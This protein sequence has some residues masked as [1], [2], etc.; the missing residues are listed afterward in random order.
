MKTKVLFKIPVYSVSDEKHYNYWKKRNEDFENAGMLKGHSKEEIE[1]GKYF[2]LRPY[3]L[4]KY[5]K[6]IGYIEIHLS[7][8]DI[9]AEIYK[10]IHIKRYQMISNRR[11]FLEKINSVGNHRKIKNMSNAEIKS[12]I[13]L[14]LHEMYKDYFS[15]RFVDKETFNNISD[16]IDYNAII[17][18]LK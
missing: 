17:S 15:G 3:C 4:W 16:F 2:L 10:V 11:Y 18:E 1:D 5:N 13:K 6:I 14:L 8:S 9:Y 12:E 7:R